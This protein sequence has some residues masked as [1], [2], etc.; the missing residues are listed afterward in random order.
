MEFAYESLVGRWGKVNCGRKVLRGRRW[1]GR[2]VAGTALGA[3]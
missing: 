2:G 1:Q 3:V